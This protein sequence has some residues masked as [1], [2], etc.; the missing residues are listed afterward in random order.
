MTKIVKV[1][2]VKVENFEFRNDNDIVTDLGIC[3]TLNDEVTIDFTPV[4]AINLVKDLGERI[5]Q[6]KERFGIL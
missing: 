3:A 6:M 2:K 5:K 4:Q 1:E